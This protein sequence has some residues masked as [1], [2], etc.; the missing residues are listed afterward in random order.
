VAAS[1][2]ISDAG[3]VADAWGVGGACASSGH[4]SIH[5]DDAVV[6]EIT[7]KMARFFRSTVA[8]S[9]PVRRTAPEHRQHAA[10]CQTIHA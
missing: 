10:A 6:A 3:R 1:A 9:R 7:A 4:G 8:A 2:L 5:P